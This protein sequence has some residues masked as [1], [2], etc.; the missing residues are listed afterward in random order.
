MVVTASL[1]V[2]TLLAVLLSPV[3][4]DKAQLL[5]FTLAVIASSTYGGLVGGLV[6]TALSFV[7]A[8]F[9]FIEPRFEILTAPGDYALLTVFLIF[10]ISL[11]VVNHAL[12]KAN[13]AI[14]ERSRELTRSNEELQRFAYAV[15]HDLQ[16][17]LRSIRAFTELF[18][19]RNRDKLDEES[20]SWLG[21]VVSGAE[22]MRGLI[23]AVLEFSVAGREAD[24]AE[25]DAGEI[26]RSAVKD[27]HTTIDR[28]G[29][30]IQIGELPTVVADQKQLGRVFLNLIGNAIKYYRGDGPVVIAIS[31]E[32]HPHEWVFSV[33]DNG[34]GVDPTHRDRIFETFQRI[35][36]RA[37]GYGL[38]LATCKRVVEQHGGKIWVE[39]EAGRGADFRFSLPKR[40][41]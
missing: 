8:D 14:V 41:D 29:A 24:L 25:A 23:Q 7:I 21:F 18:L 5:P 32:S 19:A 36:R 20:A 22:R 17:P 38:G 10:G 28:S 26:V 4:H 27:L 34:G 33:R 6:S 13:L 16:E 40:G 11:S 9:F 3:L 2:S 39:S 12:A 37:G 1:A 31:A 15:S 35:D 30:E